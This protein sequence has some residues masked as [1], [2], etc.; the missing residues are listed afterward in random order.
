MNDYPYNMPQYGGTDFAVGARISTVMK[1]VYLRMTFGLLVTA[2]VALLGYSQGFLQF[3][4]THSFVYWGLFIAEIALVIIISARITKM[5]SST[6]A[7]LFYLFAIVNGLAL[8]PIF[9]I[10]T[11][12]SIAKTFFICAGTFGAMSIYGYTTKSDL[13]KMGSILIMALFGLIIC[14]VIN[15][16][17]ANSTFE[18]IISFAGVAIFIG[19]TAW[20]TQQI[21]QM[22]QLMPASSA[23]HLATIGALNLYLDFINLFLYLLRFFGNSRD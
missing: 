22:A 18:W 9:A 17:W 19:L 1:S 12:A 2:V 21:K 5:Q 10:Y 6:A 14:S 11:Q 4:F 20:D 16:F 15:I 23:G 8:T 3:M 7:A 13:S